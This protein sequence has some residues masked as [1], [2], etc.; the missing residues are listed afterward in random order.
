MRGRGRRLHLPGVHG[1][2]HRP[3]RAV[4]RREPAAVPMLPRRTGDRVMKNAKL[5]A[6][7]VFVTCP[8]C[9]EE[10]SAPTSGSLLITA[11][12]VSSHGTLTCE[13]C[14]KQMQ[15]PKTAKVN[16]LSR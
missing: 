9:G 2:R 4:R 1:Y 14:G 11:E 8:Y 3:C 6:A 13:W 7:S 5:V 12:D 15:L 16:W 10:V